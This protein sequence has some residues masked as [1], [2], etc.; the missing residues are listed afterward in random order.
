MTA[1]HHE[2]ARRAEALGLHVEYH[3]ELPSLTFHLVGRGATRRFASL[4]SLERTVAYHEE[5]HQLTRAAAEA[6]ADGIA[7]PQPVVSQP[8]VNPVDS[9]AGRV[10]FAKA[11]KTCFACRFYSA[12]FQRLVGHCGIGGP[13]EWGHPDQQIGWASTCSKFQ[14]VEEA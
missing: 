13:A 3:P 8:V 7:N 10:E 14:P 9:H 5:L 12:P 4:A 2:I 6:I 1:A 11:N